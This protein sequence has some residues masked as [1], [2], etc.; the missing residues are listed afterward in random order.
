LLITRRGRRALPRLSEIGRSPDIGQANIQ[1]HQIN[2]PR[3]GYLNALVTVFG[4]DGFIL[5]VQ[6][7][8]IRQ[9]AAQFWIILDNEAVR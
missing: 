3:L 5:L 9:R 6:R 4:R 2:M 7:K 1:D 8:L